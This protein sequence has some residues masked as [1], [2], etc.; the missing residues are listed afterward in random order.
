[1]AVQRREPGTVDKL[2]IGGISYSKGMISGVHC[3][4]ILLQ[5]E[6]LSSTDA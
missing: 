4:C 6:A 5:E 3:K 1:M 2:Q